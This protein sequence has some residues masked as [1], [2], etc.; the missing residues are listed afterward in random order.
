MKTLL[1]IS[2]LLIS[3]ASQ[4]EILNFDGYGWGYFKG[5][6][7]NGLYNTQGAP[8][9]NDL[10]APTYSADP[11][12]GSDFAVA[13][14]SGGTFIFNGGYFSGEF[15]DGYDFSASSLSITGFL[16]GTQVASYSFGLGDGFSYQA[17]GF[18]SAVDTIE[19]RASPGWT[20][21]SHGYVIDALDVTRITPIPEPETWALSLIGVAGLVARS[22]GKRGRR[23]A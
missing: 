20:R 23:Q 15:L 19:F 11:A 1:A 5:F 7:F 14:M 16:N 13:S 21:F 3:S 12:G 18:N 2:A 8:I 10:P 22:L 9:R 17:S 6:K 4:A